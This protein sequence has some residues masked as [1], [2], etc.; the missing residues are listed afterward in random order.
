MTGCI[1]AARSLK[2][3]GTQSYL[4]QAAVRHMARWANVLYQSQYY[5]TQADQITAVYSITQTWLLARLRCAF[6]GLTTK[7]IAESPV[8]LTCR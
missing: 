3:P 4:Q 5:P 2:V 1:T 7:A 8:Q 6:A